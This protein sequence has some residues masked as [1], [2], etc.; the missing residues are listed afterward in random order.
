M[1]LKTSL[2][3]LILDTNTG[4]NGGLKWGLKSLINSYP[5]ALVN[6]NMQYLCRVLCRILDVSHASIIGGVTWYLF[7]GVY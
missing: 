1:T 2:Y 4:L 6:S 3:C 5:A 7:W